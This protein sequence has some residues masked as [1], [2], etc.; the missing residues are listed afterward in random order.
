MSVKAI[1]GQFQINTRNSSYIMLVERGY[2]FHVYWGK[3]ISFGDNSYIG[4]LLFPLILKTATA[5]FLLKE[6]LLNIPVGEGGIL[7]IRR[8]R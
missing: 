7:K 3:K 1:D 6:D 4:I 2:L 8:L 5:D